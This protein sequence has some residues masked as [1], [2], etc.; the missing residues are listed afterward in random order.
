MIKLSFFLYQSGK[1]VPPPN[2]E[3]LKNCSTCYHYLL[4]YFLNLYR[5]FLSMLQILLL[6]PINHV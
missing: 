5:F 3:I 6:V 4:N 1:S 2:K